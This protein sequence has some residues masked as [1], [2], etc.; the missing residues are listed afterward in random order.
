MDIKKNIKALWSNKEVVEVS[1]FR[2]VWMI[3]TFFIVVILISIPSY[4]G[5][6]K[7]LSDIE[8]LKG[9]DESFQ[10]L[11]NEPL[12]CYVN[13]EAMMVCLN[14][15][16]D[17]A[18]D[19]KVLYQNIIVTE[20]ITSSTLIFG[21]EQFAAIYVDEENQAY[22]VIGNYIPLKG[23]D[24]REV[25]LEYEGELSVHQQNITDIFISNIYNST[26]DQKIFLIYIT[27]FSQALIYVVII[28]FMLMIVNFRSKIRKISFIASIKIIIG[29]MVGPALLSA[30]V[31][32]FFKGW[33][34][35]VFTIIFAIRM[36]FVY[37]QV[38]R[39]TET[40]E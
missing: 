10:E 2:L 34:I 26:I 6:L 19:Y 12:P 5:L 39:T 13:E 17:Q 31:G 38:H 40:I 28:S 36:M 7:G 35:L 27:Q 22:V 15:D 25:N 23:F 20:G 18:G 16:M 21:K 29:A 24:F 37:Y 4:F 32:V 11:Y 8:L 14:Q 9:L 33:G 1:K 30:I 3:I